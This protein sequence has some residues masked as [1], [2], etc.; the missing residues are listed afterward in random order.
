MAGTLY[1]C[2]LS[3]KQVQRLV[4]LSCYR[5]LDHWV[6]T[7]LLPVTVPAQ[8]NQQARRWSF[9]DLIRARAVADMRRQG[10][11]LQRIRK[12][13]DILTERLGEGDPLAAGRLVVAGERLYWAMDEATLLDV[14]RGQLAAGPLVILDVGAI[15]RELAP[16]VA[17]LC[18]A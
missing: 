4:G 6:R 16:R 3:S 18:A 1:D 14:L 11:S 2:E 5:T 12:A 13:V 15:A 10:V 8:G 7:N 17:E 9:V